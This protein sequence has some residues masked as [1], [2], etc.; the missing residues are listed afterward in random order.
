MKPQIYFQFRGVSNLIE[1]QA[2]DLGTS[3]G[4]VQNKRLFGVQK[5]V[6]RYGIKPQ[7]LDFVEVSGYYAD[8]NKAFSP[9][10]LGA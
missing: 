10:E 9:I 1:F 7:I 4:A 6:A 2:T 8:E 5:G 3:Q